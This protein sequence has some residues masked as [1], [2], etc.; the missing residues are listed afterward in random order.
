M[1]EKKK[2]AR[3]DMTKIRGHGLADVAA[4]AASVS[5][6]YCTTTQ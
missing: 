1:M 2:E 6:F 4:A 3:G 5:L